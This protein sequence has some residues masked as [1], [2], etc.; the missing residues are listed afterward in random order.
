MM[1]DDNKIEEAARE[2]ASLYEQ[3][4]P[5]MSY[6]EDTEVDGGFGDDGENKTYVRL[7]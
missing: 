7:F 3:D 6:N 2:A 5:I 1:V 4:F